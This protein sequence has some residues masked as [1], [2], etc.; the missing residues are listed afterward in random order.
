MRHVIGA[1]ASIVFLMSS[2]AWAAAPE[3]ANDEQKTL[4]A[5]G[6]ALSQSL[7]PF[8]LNESELEFVKSGM[9]D[10][11][12]KRPQKVDLQVYGP[13]IQ[14]MQQVRS[15]ALAD[16]EKKAGSGFLAKAA[17]EPGAKKTESGAIVTTMKEGKGANPKA[18]DTVKVHYHGTLTD[19]TVFDSSVKRGEPATFPL[20]QVIK[21]WTEAVQ[22]IKV[23]G[24][25][26]LV[27][28]SGI[29]YG[30]RGSPPVIKPG[31]TLV[32]EVELLDIVKQ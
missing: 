30:D 14:Q 21:C 2:P 5:L 22:L 11:I 31:A 1:I 4:Y 10:G 8:T 15:S 20:N 24:K 3:P 16:V 18:T 6:V 32:F 7:E 25:S 12:L 19:G 9:A 17:A 28:P 26:R 13:K 29:A 27:C 23:G